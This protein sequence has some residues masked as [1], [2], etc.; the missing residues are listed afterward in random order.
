METISF[1]GDS[2]AFEENLRR[3]ISKAKQAAVTLE[4]HEMKTG[5]FRF[6]RDQRDEGL[7]PRLEARY[8]VLKQGLDDSEVI[9]SSI[10]EYKKLLELLRVHPQEIEKILNH[11]N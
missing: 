11:E 1:T 7:G 5:E 8:Q 3:K 4:E 6:L 10:M 9:V 2:K